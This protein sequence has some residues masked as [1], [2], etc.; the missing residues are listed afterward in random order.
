[1]LRYNQLKRNLSGI[2]NMVLSQS[3][4]NLESHNIVRR[5]QYNE[6]P[7]RVEYSLTD[8][9]QKILPVLL[10]LSKKEHKQ[11]CK[12][13]CNLDYCNIYE[14]YNNTITQLDTTY[15]KLYNDILNSDKYR[16]YHS[17]D[18]MKL[19]FECSLDTISI[20]GHDYTKYMTMQF[21]Q[22]DSLKD[23]VTSEDRPIYTILNILIT[24]GKQKGEIITNLTNEQITHAITAFSRGAIHNWE[25]AK[26]SYDIVEKNKDIIDWFFS[27]LKAKP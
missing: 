16:D 3:L 25:L 27:N 4:K 10:M 20:I 23:Y 14:K 19:I 18:I 17:A 13:Q 21:L 12:P 26:G 9:G 22:Q 24:T 7:P 8:I 6:I 15:E 2:T 1:M 5:V 11:S